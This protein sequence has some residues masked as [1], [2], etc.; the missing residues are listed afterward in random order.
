MDH[1]ELRWAITMEL[2]FQKKLTGCSR[3]RQPLE[4]F[5]KKSCSNIFLQIHRKT[6]VPQ[7]LFNSIA[8]LRPGTLLKKDFGLSVFLRILPNFKDIFFTEAEHLQT[9]ASGLLTNFA[10]V[11]NC[12]WSTWSTMQCK[13]INW[14]LFNRNFYRKVFPNRLLKSWF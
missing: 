14:F 9:T 6:P 10:E 13:P 4:V 11:F 3:Q 5:Y 7:P 8:G 1:L 2:F 12:R